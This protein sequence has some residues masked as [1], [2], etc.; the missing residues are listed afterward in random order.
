MIEKRHHYQRGPSTLPDDYYHQSSGNGLDTGRNLANHVGPSFRNRR[1]PRNLQYPHRS[2]SQQS[3]VHAG[4]HPL[5]PDW[6]QCRE[7]VGT[8]VE[9]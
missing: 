9:L 6:T 2:R 7:Q 1:T 3:I 4:L 8:V 5:E